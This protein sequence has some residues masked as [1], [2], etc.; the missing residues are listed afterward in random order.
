[1]Y[2]AAQKKIQK[3][4]CT[5]VVAQLKALVEDDRRAEAVTLFKVWGMV[6]DYDC[7][8]H[9]VRQTKLHNAGVRLDGW[10]TR[11]ERVVIKGVFSAAQRQLR[12]G[13]N[14]WLGA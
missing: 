11:N 12:A 6:D 7:R 9:R 4:T 8:A 5:K 3:Q 14:M 1:M 2:N 10:M 13:A